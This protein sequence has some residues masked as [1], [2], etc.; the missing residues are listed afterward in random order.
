[1]DPAKG[2][3]GPFAGV[4]ACKINCRREYNRESDNVDR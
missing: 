1:L 4:K 3:A 2:V